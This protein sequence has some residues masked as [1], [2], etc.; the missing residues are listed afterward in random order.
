M[1]RVRTWLSEAGFLIED[2][3]EDGTTRVNTYPSRLARTE[4]VSV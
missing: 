1:E 3:A 2:D 4:V